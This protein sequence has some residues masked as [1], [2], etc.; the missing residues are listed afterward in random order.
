MA[1]EGVEHDFPGADYTTRVRSG[2]EGLDELIEGGF[3]KG[4]SILMSGE[5]GTGKTTFCSQYLYYGAKEY[6]ETGMYISFN[7]RPHEL[8][9][10]MAR[11]GMDFRPLERAKKLILVDGASPRARIETGEKFVL[12]P[13]TDNVVDVIKK[14][15]DYGRRLGVRRMVLDSLADIGMRL[16]QDEI[17]DQ[18]FRLFTILTASGSTNMVTVEKPTGTNKLSPYGIEEFLAHGILVLGYRRQGPILMR[19]IEIRKMRGTNHDTGLFAFDFAV[20]G[21]KMYPMPTEMAPF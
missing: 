19:T 3:P 10:E 17:R 1:D 20:E 14:A 9:Q 18:M 2:I 13:K 8:R 5:C 6:G 16:P 15:V 4:C 12:I 7:E 21:I 11:F